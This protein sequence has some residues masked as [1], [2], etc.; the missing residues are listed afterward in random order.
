M[1]GGA[2]GVC[3][4]W[5]MMRAFGATALLLLIPGGCDMVEVAGPSDPDSHGLR[6]ELVANG[7]R[8]T[9]TVTPTTV[10]QPGTVL[11]R[12]RYENLTNADVVLSSGYGC[13]SFAGVYRDQVRIPFPETD[14]FCTTVITA[15]PIGPGQQ[16]GMDWTLHLGEGGVVLG[17]GEYRFVARL[18]THNRELSRTFV[19]E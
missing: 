6:S 1:L 4:R 11:A 13:L 19:V 9:L 15:F 12:L 16:I 18:N 3:R 14:Y 5:I 10:S 7:V 17:P 2:G 8:V